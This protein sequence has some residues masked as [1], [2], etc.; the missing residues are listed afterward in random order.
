[1]LLLW[2]QSS[3]KRI[4]SLYFQFDLNLIEFNEISTGFFNTIFKSVYDLPFNCGENHLMVW[5]EGI[6]ISI[7]KQT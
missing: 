1:M 7:E 4:G 5:T 6:F 3:G 2:F